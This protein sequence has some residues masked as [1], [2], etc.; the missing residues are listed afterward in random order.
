MI[1]RQKTAWKAL[2]KTLTYENF[3]EDFINSSMSSLSDAIKLPFSTKYGRP[4]PIVY[5][6]R[7]NLKLSRLSN[8]R[9]RLLLHALS[10]AL[11]TSNFNDIPN[12]QPR[13]RLCSLCPLNE[14][15]DLHHFI[16]RCPSLQPIRDIWFPRLYEAPPLSSQV[17]NHVLGIDWFEDQEAILRFVADLYSARAKILHSFPSPGYSSHSRRQQK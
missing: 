3:Q 9:F 13:S 5:H 12:T 15:E 11:H 10:L 6:F 8:L 2:A 7:H 16:F 14:T 4:P 1:Y 17:V